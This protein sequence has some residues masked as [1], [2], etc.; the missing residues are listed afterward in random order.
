[1]MLVNLF[2]VFFV[3]ALFFYVGIVRTDIPPFM[4]PVLLGLGAIIVLY[5]IYKA[6]IKK[7]AWVNY[8]HIFLVG[9]LLMWIGWNG[10]ETP[11]KYFELL[12]MLAFATIGYHG[13]YV[14]SGDGVYTV[15]TK[16]S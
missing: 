7:H 16:P 1:M 8:I 11:R 13:Y 12:L 15:S 14:L 6:T 2:H 3:S 4:F 5:H 9:P 10:V